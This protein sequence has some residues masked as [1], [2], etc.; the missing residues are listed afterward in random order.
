MGGGD[1]PE[2]K[3]LNENLEFVATAP[4]PKRKRTTTPAAKKSAVDVKQHLNTFLERYAKT[5]ATGAAALTVGTV[6]ALLIR[7]GVPPEA[8]SAIIRNLKP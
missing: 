1:T 2:L 5:M 4:T 8:F 6:S 7:F 3:R